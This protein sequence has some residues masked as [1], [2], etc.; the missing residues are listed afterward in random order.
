VHRKLAKRASFGDRTFGYVTRDG[1]QLTL[2]HTGTSN[3]LYW[4]GKYEPETTSVYLRLAEDAPTILDIGAADGLYA[5]LAAAANPRARVLAF[6]PG[7]AAAR[8]IERNLALNPDVTRQI[9]LHEI[10]LA[11]EDSTATLYIAGE[12]GGTSSLNP[13]FRSTHVE[14]RVTVRRGET[15]LSELGLS[16][17]DL[18]KLDTESTEPTVL[19]GLGRVLEAGPDIICEVLKGRT[20]RDLERVLGPL[21]FSYYAMTTAGLVRHDTIEADGTYR[22]P[23]YLF[24]RRSAADLEALGF[25]VR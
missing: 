12:S 16:R 9:S 25:S 7:R 10:A 17:V 22:E 14:E 23:N 18:I 11:D 13:A 21:G 8:T 5:I 1:T 2:L 24:T 15:F 6:E 19:R 3:Y 4:L 20:E